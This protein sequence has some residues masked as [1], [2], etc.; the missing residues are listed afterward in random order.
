MPPPVLYLPVCIAAGE[1]TRAPR[2]H[3][4]AANGPLCECVGVDI[5]VVAGRP[6]PYLSATLT[7]LCKLLCCKAVAVPTAMRIA[8]GTRRLTA[9]EASQD[10][11]LTSSTA[12][13]PTGGP[14]DRVFHLLSAFVL[15]AMDDAAHYCRVVWEL[16]YLATSGASFR[17][18]CAIRV[19]RSELGTQTQTPRSS[20]KDCGLM[21]LKVFMHAKD[22]AGEFL[23]CYSAQ[24][25]C[26]K[27]LRKRSIRSRSTTGWQQLRTATRLISM[28]GT[29]MGLA[30]IKCNLRTVPEWD[31][32]N[33]DQYG[34][35]VTCVV[36]LSVT[37]QIKSAL[38]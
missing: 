36:R 23:S 12:G 25:K 28:R 20:T 31:D 33:Q 19:T 24:W 7:N 9:V 30:V 4:S 18:L 34:R 8:E 22:K 13:G 1:F 2:G 11:A 3:S 21:V 37:A 6:Y 10:W 32:L 14:T 38:W 5:V 26:N 27:L 16:H 15:V 29:F 35:D 17:P